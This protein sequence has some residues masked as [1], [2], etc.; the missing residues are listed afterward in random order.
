MEAMFA[1]ML[2]F[3][4]LGALNQTLI[5]AAKVRQNTAAMDQAIEEFHA[6]LT[7]KSDIE[8]ALTLANPAVNSTGS[9]LVLNRVNPDLP[10]T[11]RIDSVLGSADPFESAEQL[12]IT[13]EIQDGVLKR[14]VKQGTSPAV[15]QRLI[16]AQTLR[17]ER[18]GGARGLVTVSLSI[19]GPR[20]TKTRVIK[21]AVR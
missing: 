10:F 17:V 11:D 9:R 8:A 3:M 6:L 5:N 15:V 13:Y 18:T 12:T 4:I 19:E 14:L 7:I 20:V 16:P 1:F 21:A 2:V